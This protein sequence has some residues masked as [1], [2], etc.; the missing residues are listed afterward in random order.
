MQEREKDQE[1]QVTPA[2]T[3]PN[4]QPLTP[5]SLV[6]VDEMDNDPDEI[7]L[8]AVAEIDTQ[9]L[10]KVRK[11]IVINFMDV[12]QAL[13]CSC[14]I[15]GS[16]AGLIWQA[17]T[18][19]KTL[20]ILY[21]VEKPATLTTTL[22]IPTRTLA[23]VTLMRSAS[24]S[25]TGHGHQ[26]ARP[27]TGALTFYNGQNTP[28]N[29]PVGTVLTGQDGVKITTDQPALVPAASLPNVGVVTI[30]ARAIIAGSNG[31][32]AP[33]DI[34]LAL[35]NDLTVKNQTSFT[36]GR[37]A[38]TY[39]AVGQQDIQ[40]LTSTVQKTLDTAF[41]TAF[42]LR[43]G[44]EA[45]PTNCHTTTT[46]N[47]RIGE[48][49]QTVTLNGSETCSAVAYSQDTVEQRERQ[50][51]TTQTA[52]GKHYK[53][54]GSLTSTIVSLYPLT[55]SL[56]GSWVYA[57]NSDD[58]QSLAQAIQGET[59]AQARAYLLKTGVI[60]QAS[61]PNTLPPAM[62]IQFLVLACRNVGGPGQ[63]N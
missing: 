40:N 45:Q 4:S 7:F 12:L 37:D 19:P 2:P 27:A 23:P 31:N 49:A 10:V 17:I 39:Q 56:T 54:V 55:V 61:V 1:T 3:D 63:C 47:H 28:Q 11:P 34:N 38:R 5:L 21:T 35:T 48:E 16:M 44:E 52:P 41:T 30:S 62:Y 24:T 22:D 26:D 42:P 57:L 53:L 20:V 18:Y 60:A 36:N 25:T 8:N 50:L 58:Q 51:F 15:V 29:I 59:P 13:L 14:L 32:I 6:Q 46:A 9:P 33:Y 43:S